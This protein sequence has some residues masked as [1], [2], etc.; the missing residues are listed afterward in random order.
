MNLVELTDVLGNVGDFIGSI[1]VIVT[2]IYLAIQIRQINRN[3]TLI[4]LQA[5]R[6]ERISHGR[7]NR[8]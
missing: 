3:S 2:L 5:T 8:D 1:A 4:A 7:S 6:A